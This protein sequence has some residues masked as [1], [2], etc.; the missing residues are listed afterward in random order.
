MEERWD[1]AIL[2][3]KL[4]IGRALLKAVGHKERQRDRGV[5]GIS[6]PARALEL[7]KTKEKKKK[8]GDSENK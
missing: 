4:L 8:K 1:D 5:V 6:D 2:L 3:W 7:Y